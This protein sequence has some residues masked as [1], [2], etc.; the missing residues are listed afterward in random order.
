MDFLKNKHL[1]MAMFIAPILAVIAYFAVDNIVSEEP[2]AA[3][4]GASYQLVAKSNCRYKSGICTLE[5]G[6]VEVKIRLE[7]ID[8]EQ[9]KIYLS[10]E[11]PVQHAV[12]SF[13]NDI[14]Y[15][16]VETIPTS[17]QLLMAGEKEQANVWSAVLNTV[18]KET[19]VMRLVVGISDA[20]YYAETTS[21]FIDYETAFSRKNFSTNVETY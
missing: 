11:L 13:V 10:S 7:V 3:V 17:L 9:S 18:P 8:A 4:E 16:K 20:L 21:V 19:S 14:G 2:H 5:N 6:D 1:I 12:I 15:E